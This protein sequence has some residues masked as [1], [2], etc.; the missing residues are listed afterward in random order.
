MVYQAKM[1]NTKISILALISLVLFILFSPITY[2]IVPLQLSDQ[3]TSVKDSAG[4]N[5]MKFEDENIL[6]I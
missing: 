1:K 5:T 4:Q 3:G 6:G 2:S